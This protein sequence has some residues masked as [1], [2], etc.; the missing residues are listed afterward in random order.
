MK[1]NPYPDYKEAGKEWYNSIPIEY[2]VKKIKYICKYITDGSHF[3]PVSVDEGKPYVTV[4]DLIDGIINYEGALKVSDEDFY[5]LE[6]AGCRPRV[7]DVL[8]SKDGTVGKVALVN[9]D[10]LV[11]LSSLAILRPK[12]DVNPKYLMYQ[13]VSKSGGAQI[14]SFFF[15]AALKRITLDI[16]VNLYGILPPLNI[17]NEIVYYLDKQT[18]KIDTLI[19]KKQ[20]QIELLEEKRTDLITHTVTKGLNPLAKMKDSGI[21]W[22][23]MIPEHWEVWKLSHLFRFEKGT[24]AQLY[25]KEY[26]GEN[27]GDYPVYS[28][29]TENDGI[30][31]LVNRYDY[32]TDKY[33]FVT[34]VGANAMDV[35][36]I[37]GKY[38]LSQNCA[39]IIPQLKN[40]DVDY[41]AFQL[42]VSFKYEKKVLPAIMQPSL[43]FDD[44]NTFRIVKPP[45]QEQKE[46][47]KLLKMKITSIEKQVKLI[48]K[49]IN[50]LQEYRTSL[51][52]SAVTGKINVS[53]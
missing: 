45:L 10:N 24:N 53:I 4:K 39:L 44:L 28:G 1:L 34:T 51:I 19:A 17:Q 2:E 35:K 8:F 7:G 31:G 23:G 47:T 26:I 14:E 3:S 50:L 37:E 52:T 46:I 32:D 18:N 5:A 25:T 43:R 15:G 49:S 36:V 48:T 12:S 33:I 13:I 16:I 22:L 20:R 38:A 21:E 27:E 40:L 41:F 9:N 42:F 11:V 29:Q 6:K 30:M